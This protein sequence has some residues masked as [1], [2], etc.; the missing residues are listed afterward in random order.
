MLTIQPRPVTKALFKMAEV[1]LGKRKRQPEPMDQQ[2]T[3]DSPLFLS[4]C[5][6]SG[7]LTNAPVTP[8]LR[9][10]Q[11]TDSRDL[12]SGPTASPSPSIDRPFRDRQPGWQEIEEKALVE[13][14]LLY[15]NGDSWP[16]TKDLKYWDSAA[17]FIHERSGLQM[18]SG[19][20]VELCASWLLIMFSFHKLMLVE[21][22]H[23][24]Q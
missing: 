20:Y 19:T 14:I 24:V 22:G 18:R 2:S 10:A 6:A 11:K 17:K 4:D 15:G 12:L 13:F 5:N 16:A 9:L 8:S 23:Q 21:A 7:L 3:S 1:Q